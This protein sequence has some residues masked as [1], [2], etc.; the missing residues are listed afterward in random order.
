MPLSP[1]RLV[2]EDVEHRTQGTNSVDLVPSLEC[3]FAVVAGLPS[4]AE[5]PRCSHGL[6]LILDSPTTNRPE[7]PPSQTFF[8]TFHISHTQ[9][10]SRLPTDYS[11]LSL[12]L[13]NLSSSILQGAARTDLLNHQEL[14]LVTSYQAQRQDCI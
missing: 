9:P 11:G 2:V 14:N 5:H 12:S 1:G 3:R 4:R 10:T 7:L 6:H 8:T 13:P